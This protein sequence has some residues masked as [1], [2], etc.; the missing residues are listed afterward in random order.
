MNSLCLN[1]APP[2]EPNLAVML[3]CAFHFIMEN[4]RM[5]GLGRTLMVRVGVGWVK[6][7]IANL[8][9]CMDHLLEKF[10]PIC[11]SAPGLL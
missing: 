10:M 11:I 5:S 6:T 8:V 7:P 2:G 3:F 4:S 1:K 9:K